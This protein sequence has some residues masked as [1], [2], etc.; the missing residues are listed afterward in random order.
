MRGHQG[1]IRP[2][3]CL[4]AATIEGVVSRLAARRAHRR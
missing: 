4:A 3:A 2:T 1:S